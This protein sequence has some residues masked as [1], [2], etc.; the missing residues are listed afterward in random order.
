MP[1]GDGKPREQ[2]VVKE[3]PKLGW[4]PL[5]AF[6]APAGPLLALSLPPIVFLP[7]YYAGH[8]G[9]D[10][11]TVGLLF[12]AARA[13]DI[14]ANP[15]IGSLQDR[16]RTRFGRRRPW[17]VAATPLMMLIVWVAFI[18]FEP[19]ASAIALGLAILALY[20]TFAC[21]MIA[22]L[23]WA[24]E[25][26]P[27]YHGR[28]RVLGAVQIASTAGQIVILAMPAAV[29]AG[30][31]SFEDGV[32]AMG[33]AIIVALPL[34]VAL[35]AAFA[36]EPQRAPQPG[37][38]FAEAMNALRNNKSL[39]QI[40]A[41]DFLVGA[42]QGVSGSLFVFFFEH[43]LGFGDRATALLFAYFVA[44]L[45]GV[46]I[47]VVLAR[48]IGKHRALQ[49]GC[50]WWAVSFLLIPISPPGQ[51]WLALAGIGF[52]GLAQGPGVLLLRSMMADVADED[53]LAS[54]R[55]RP[56]LFFGL[57][58]TTTKIGLAIGPLTYVALGAFGFDAELGAGNGPQAMMA[59]TLLFAG[60][61]FVL[62]LL[63]AASLNGYAL[64]QTR[65][66]ALRAALAARASSARQDP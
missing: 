8:L 15:I 57:L 31:G 58:L 59:L 39:R 17:L 40:L 47:W 61:P 10:E 45:L 33:W 26:Q 41:P 55:S 20:S 13:F 52:A 28:T 36:P 32:H 51:I 56:G 43:A 38:G 19:G 2:T 27:D 35:A 3:A 30:G 25:L 4:L 66:E 23:G 18:G 60:S 34:C 54:G 1:D 22:H 63:A 65:Q 48:R 14:V 7:P 49:V 37:G 5:A 44:G 9:V 64:D 53:E 21:M 24:G 46:P 6:A 50:L 62:N 29:Q 16:T 11:A 12:V 42:V